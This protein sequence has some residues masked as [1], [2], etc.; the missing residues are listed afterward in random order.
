[1]GDITNDYTYRRN[2]IIFT[3]KVDG[4][5]YKT[6]TTYF[7]DTSEV[8]E[9]QI[10]V[11]SVTELNI[12]Q[13]LGLNIVV[14]DLIRIQSS[15][16]PKVDILDT[17]QT[18]ENTYWYDSKQMNCTYTKN[19]VT[20]T[21]KETKETKYIDLSNKEIYTNKRDLDVPDNYTFVTAVTSITVTNK[22]INALVN[23]EY[24]CKH[25]LPDNIAVGDTNCS[26]W[27]SLFFAISSQMISY[28]R[29]DAEENLKPKYARKIQKAYNKYNSGAL[30]SVKNVTRGVLTIPTIPLLV[31]Y[32]PV[33]MYALNKM[34]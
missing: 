13:E 4:N 12:L 15:Q 9:R 17:I 8:E 24:Y 3:Q 26:K 27:K 31:I 30:R 34:T 14:Q 6:Q 32:I 23:C 1:M 10:F 28:Q 21:N 2:K 7:L 5:N 25:Y 22:F 19:I 33:V 18:E 16:L 20:I 29:I 11:D